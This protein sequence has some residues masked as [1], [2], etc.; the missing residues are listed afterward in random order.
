M[1]KINLGYKEFLKKSLILIGITLI[2]FTSRNI[3]RLEK[4]INQYNYK[5][6]NNYYFKFIGGDEKFYFRY[7][8]YIKKNSKNFDRINIGGKNI[9]VINK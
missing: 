4:E 1:R 3:Q 8:L 5:P 7:N 6:L 2:I 9:K